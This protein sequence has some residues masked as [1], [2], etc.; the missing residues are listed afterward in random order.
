MG[1]ACGQQSNTRLVKVTSHNEYKH[2]TFTTCRSTWG[3]GGG[4]KKNYEARVPT[5]DKSFPRQRRP[6]KISIYV[7]TEM[8]DNNSVHV[9]HPQEKRKDYNMSVEVSAP[10]F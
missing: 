10:L 4:D 9:H 7:M 8:N 1:Q 6:D 5:Q 2:F 3:G